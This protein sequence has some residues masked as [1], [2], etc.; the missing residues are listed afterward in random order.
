MSI[1]LLNLYNRP[2]LIPTMSWKDNTPPN[3]AT[4]LAG[5]KLANNT[6]SLSWIN[7]TAAVATELDVVK[8]FAIYRGVNAMPDINNATNLFA[9]TNTDVSTYIDTDV[10]PSTTYNYVVTAI[11]RLYNESVVSNTATVNVGALPLNLIS[12][13]VEKNGNKTVS[14]KWQT[15][16]EINT[17]FFEVQRSFNN[18][19]FNKLVLIKANDGSAQFNYNTT[20]YHLYENGLYSYRLKMVD[21]DGKFTFSEIKKVNINN[22]KLDLTAYPNPVV[23]GGNLQLVWQGANGIVDYTII[24]MNGKIVTKNN[25]QFYGGIANLSLS[26]NMASGNY[27]L[28]C[29]KEGEIYSLKIVVQ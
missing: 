20:D 11:D 14:L 23:K 29:F 12:F 8:R 6:I 25:V 22:E 1:S 7:P 5:V 26:N 3:A 16:N 9:I 15:A 18:N 19:G 2:A 27:I 10:M 4:N 17:D 28:Q 13:D 21:K 24:Q